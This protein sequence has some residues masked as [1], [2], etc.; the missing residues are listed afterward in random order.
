MQD[1]VDPF[2]TP[3]NILKKRTNHYMKKITILSCIILM[4]SASVEKA[5]AQYYFYDNKYYDSP[6]LFELGG[7]V[8]IMNCL[9]DLGG[10]KG[11]GKKFIKD[12]NMGKTKLA[13][14]IYLSAL[15]KNAF[16][17]RLEATFGTCTKYLVELAAK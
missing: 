6:L 16:A 4:L 2:K 3:A 1:I 12:L 14:S 15:Y 13:G 17:I 7:S 10:R 5:S 8:G 9:T 11:I